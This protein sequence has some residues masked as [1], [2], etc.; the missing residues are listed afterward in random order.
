VRMDHLGGHLIRLG[1]AKPL[2]LRT[3]PPPGEMR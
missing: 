3:R 2:R 1:A